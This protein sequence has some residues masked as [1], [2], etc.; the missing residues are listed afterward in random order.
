M[1]VP[2]NKKII[3]SILAPLTG[4]AD[5]D[6]EILKYRLIDKNNKNEITTILN[7]VVK[8][9]FDLRSGGYKQLAETT[10]SYYLTNDKLDFGPFYDSLLFAVD[11]P[12]NPKLFFE[13][14][15][16]VLFGVKS[17]LLPDCNTCREVS[18]TEALNNL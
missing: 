8:P 11:H 7:D 6:E 13:W 3:E 5:M 12:E 18:N 4:G 15:W 1:Q 17:F 14:L 16:E 10:L 9:V 2:V